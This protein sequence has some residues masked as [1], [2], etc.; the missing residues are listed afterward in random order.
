M[1]AA[2]LT[3]PVRFQLVGDKTVVR[4]YAQIAPSRQFCRLLC[5]VDNLPPEPVHILQTR[6]EFPLNRERNLEIQRIDCRHEQFTYGPVKI[7]AGYSLALHITGRQASGPATTW[8]PKLSGT[9]SRKR[10]T[11]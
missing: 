3:V 6:L 1:Q 9:E 7:A 2:Q 8:R 11:R 5:P 10:R 4:I